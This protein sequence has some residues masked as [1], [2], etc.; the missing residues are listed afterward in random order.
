MEFQNN[1]SRPLFIIIL[2]Q[3]WC[4]TSVRIFCVLPGTKNSVPLSNLKII[5]CS[6]WDRKIIPK[7]VF[8]YVIVIPMYSWPLLQGIEIYQWVNKVDPQQ[9]YLFLY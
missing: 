8:H 3:N 4:Q 2:S 9:V 6:L 7:L 5:F 1:F